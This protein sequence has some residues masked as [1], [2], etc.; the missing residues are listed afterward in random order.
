MILITDYFFYDL[1]EAF[2]NVLSVE[3]TG[4]QEN[5]ILVMPGQGVG[6]LYY[7]NSALN[8]SIVVQNLNSRDGLEIATAIYNRYRDQINLE[9]TLPETYLPEENPRSIN[10]LYIQ[11]FD[12]P[13]PL[14]D[15]GSGR[16]QF[17][18]NFSIQLGGLE[19]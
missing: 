12:R 18:L 5:F 4:K 11:P 9:L 13:V 7:T 2:E 14:G 10:C 15:V 1:K 16:F 19:I 17:S 6:S 8:L 3:V